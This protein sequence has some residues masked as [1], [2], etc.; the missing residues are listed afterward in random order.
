MSPEE[1]FMLK[2]LLGSVDCEPQ[3]PDEVPAALLQMQCSA[4]QAALN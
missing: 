1:L 3:L 4:T 2:A